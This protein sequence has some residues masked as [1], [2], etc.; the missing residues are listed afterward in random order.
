[1]IRGRDVAGFQFTFLQFDEAPQGLIRI[2]FQPKHLFF[3][4]VLTEE[5]I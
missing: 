4:I 3:A 2:L 1:M 5:N